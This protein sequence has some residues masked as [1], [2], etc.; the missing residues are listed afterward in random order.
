MDVRKIGAFISEQRKIK[1]YTQAELAA[2][3]NVSHQAVSK[4]E[5]GES[6]PDIGM[7]PGLAKL[8][9][10]TVDELLNGEQSGLAEEPLNELELELELS[11][12]APIEEDAAASL[13][14]PLSPLSTALPA[15][16]AAAEETS[17]GRQSMTW[18]HI[19][20]L[21]PFLNQE[22]L[23]T[24]IGQIEDDLDWPA[25]NA[26][27]P[28]VG[29]SAME[30]LVDK[31]VETP[32]DVSQLSGIA[33]FLGRDLLE[34]L[35]LHADENSVDWGTLQALAPFVD[36]SSLSRL[37][38]Q[39]MDSVPEPWQIIGLAPFLDKAALVQAVGRIEAASLS[40]EILPG[41]APFLPQEQLNQ[42]VLQFRRNPV[43]T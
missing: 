17:T 9:D 14:G 6:L 11:P 37:V 13:A 36:R 10:I 42:L 34:R 5:R 29:R 23:E 26:L 41:L 24:M 20:S 25:L 3:L 4:W 22:T 16:S 28:F 7:L 18:N 21:A 30:Q 32:V 12:E 1:D 35:L 43:S 8:L 2:L 38:A 27:A 15:S 40:P 19:M 39:A 31:V 33:P